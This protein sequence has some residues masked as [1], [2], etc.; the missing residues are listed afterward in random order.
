MRILPVLAKSWSG[1]LF[2][3]TDGKVYNEIS[4]MAKIL[5]IEDDPELILWIVRGESKILQGSFC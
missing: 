2:V 5:L 1:F 4:D 3:L